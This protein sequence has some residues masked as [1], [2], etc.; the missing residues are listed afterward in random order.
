MQV[1]YLDHVSVLIT[2][3]IMPGMSGM[4]F[5]REAMR[6]Q[7]QVPIVLISGFIEKSEIEAARAVGIKEVL[8]K[9]D[10][11]DE[12]AR[13]IHRLLSAAAITA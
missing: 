1:T 8:L 5:A 3:L 12:L 6:L 11:V 13:T 4:E 7:P 10:T 9:P 2:D